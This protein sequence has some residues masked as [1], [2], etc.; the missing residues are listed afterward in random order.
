MQEIKISKNRLYLVPGGLYDMV[1]GN[2]VEQQVAKM[3]LLVSLCE[4]IIDGL[5]DHN[6]LIEE[7][8]PY[9][10]ELMK[11]AEKL[12]D[13]KYRDL[14]ENY[15]LH[16]LE[17]PPNPKYPNTIPTW[18]Q[19]EPWVDQSWHNDVCPSFFHPDCKIVVWVHPDRSEDREY[20]IKKF[21]V[22]SVEVC[23]EGGQEFS[24]EL[25][26]CETEAELKHWLETATI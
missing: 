5:C 2:S 9:C 3:H 4:K 10:N 11:I 7:R 23:E 22:N 14:V 20:E 16:K 6:E 18:L 26:E 15:Q 17:F 21:F 19:E 1:E 8:T 24:A 12:Y 25:F 13:E